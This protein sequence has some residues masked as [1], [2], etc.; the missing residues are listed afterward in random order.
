VIRLAF[1]HNVHG[2]IVIRVSLYRPALDVMTVREVGLAAADDPTV[3]AWAAGE[4]RVLITQDERTMPRYAYD[5]VRRSMPGVVVVS[6]S[7]GI[8]RAVED[9]LILATCGEEDELEN[10]VR[11]LPL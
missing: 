10:Q 6:Q 1:D 7:L 8:R 2:T 4:R 5:R 3:L 11:Y 9:I